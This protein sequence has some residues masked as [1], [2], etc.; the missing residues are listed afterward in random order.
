MPEEKVR[1]IW[2]HESVTDKHFEDYYEL[3]K[4]LGK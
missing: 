1:D 4:E 2:L 3:G